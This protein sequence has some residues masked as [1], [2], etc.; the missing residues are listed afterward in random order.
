MRLDIGITTIIKLY[1]A[2]GVV[3]LPREDLEEVA[4]D[5]EGGVAVLPPLPG[6]AD[7]P[8]CCSDVRP[9]GDGLLLVVTRDPNRTGMPK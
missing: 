8:R 7:R 2:V 3:R 1:P 5:V 9:E 4:H 6:G